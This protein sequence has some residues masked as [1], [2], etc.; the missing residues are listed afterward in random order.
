VTSTRVALE[1]IRVG[2]KMISGPAE[3][4]SDWITASTP[5]RA[6]YRSHLERVSSYFFQFWMINRNPSG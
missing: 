4:P 5:L 3:T 1:K 6:R 2:L